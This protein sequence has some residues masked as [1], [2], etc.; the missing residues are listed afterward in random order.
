MRFVK[1]VFVV[2]S[3]QDFWITKMNIFLRITKFFSTSAVVGKNRLL[4]CSVSSLSYKT[5]SFLDCCYIHNTQFFGF[6]HFFY[7]QTNNKKLVFHLICNISI[8]NSIII[9]Y[10]HLKN[11][12]KNINLNY[13]FQIYNLKTEF[14]FVQVAFF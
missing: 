5:C 11:Y 4:L 14:I 8:S 12:I 3:W 6:I 10:I 13:S 1:I 7:I 2:P 9:H